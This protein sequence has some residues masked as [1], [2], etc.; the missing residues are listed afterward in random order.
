MPW[1]EMIFIIHFFLFFSPSLCSES[2]RWPVLGE[3]MQDEKVDPIVCMG[4]VWSE[5]MSVFLDIARR[6]A[7]LY[8][9]TY[10]TNPG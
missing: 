1:R 4:I 2:N 6:P 5:W 10:G 9:H 7:L 3:M 8:A